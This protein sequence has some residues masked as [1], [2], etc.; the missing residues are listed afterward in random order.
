[1]LHKFECVSILYWNWGHHEVFG[2]LSV[3]FVVMHSV[4]GVS[5][6]LV[7]ILVLVLCSVVLSFLFF[8]AD[9]YG[10]IILESLDYTGAFVGYF[11][12]FRTASH[13]SDQAVS[14]NS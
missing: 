8:P 13:V 10:L 4:G 9:I 11:T 1:M 6:L 3:V 2:M 12:L 14:L 5:W 7:L